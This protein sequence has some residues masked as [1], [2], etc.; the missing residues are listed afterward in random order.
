MNNRV[1]DR[2]LF[3]HRNTRISKRINEEKD[4]NELF[5]LSSKCWTSPLAKQKQCFQRKHM[6]PVRDGNLS[7]AANKLDLDLGYIENVLTDNNSQQ[8]Q[9]SESDGCNA[10]TLGQ[11]AE[12]NMASTMADVYQEL[13]VYAKDEAFW[14]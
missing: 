7:P 5:V 2:A 8:P 12:S 14:S 13:A 3:A 6:S 4:K 9:I 11:L 10:V 1:G